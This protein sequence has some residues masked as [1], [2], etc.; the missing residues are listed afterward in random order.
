MRTH[1]GSL[2]TNFLVLGRVV[3]CSASEV[4]SGRSLFHLLSQVDDEGA[5]LVVL[6]V[7]RW[8]VNVVEEGVDVEHGVLVL[9]V[10]TVLLE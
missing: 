1:L 6:F 3:T 2:F 9:P 4:V 10:E 7:I 8:V 5:L